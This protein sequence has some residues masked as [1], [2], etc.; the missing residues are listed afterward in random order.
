MSN[1][2]RSSKNIYLLESSPF[3]HPLLVLS[4][5][6]L[7]RSVSEHLQPLLISAAHLRQLQQVFTTEL[8]LGLSDQPATPSSML[9]V[10]TFVPALQSLKREELT[11]EYVSLDIGSSNFRVL[12]SRLR[13][14]KAAD[15]DGKDDDHFE[16]KYY[17][18]PV[19]YRKGSSS[20]VSCTI[21][22]QVTEQYNV[23]P[24]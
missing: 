8:L 13:P 16:V 7:G 12:Y 4:N 22:P 6:A 10:N 24:F 14:K 5:E 21:R 11:G 2:H 9:M 20:R 1:N 19:E 17:D 18:I 23:L 15:V 3:H